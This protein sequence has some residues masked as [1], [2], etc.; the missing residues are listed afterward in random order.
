MKKLQQGLSLLEVLLV[1]AIAA[2]ILLLT[3]RY[4]AISRLE[5]KVAQSVSLIQKI[6]SA[7][8][9][10]LN[11]QSQ[12]DFSGPTVISMYPLQAA[13]Y[14]GT[15]DLQDPWGGTILVSPG[16]NPQYVQIALPKVPMD[17][18]NSLKQR[19]AKSAFQQISNCTSSSG[20]Y[21][22]F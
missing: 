2:T 1:V 4:F 17:A 14:L 11:G 8:Y 21:G 18:C 20:Y 13:N 7:S 6:S 19:L 3:T 12:A 22:S 5:L 15:V 10:W 16:P 9:L